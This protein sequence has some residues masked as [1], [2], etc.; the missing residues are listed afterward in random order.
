[1]ED[2]TL[3]ENPALLSP[4]FGT[5][6]VSHQDKTFWANVRTIGQVLGYTRGDQVRLYDLDDL[7][8]AMVKSGLNVAH[9]VNSDGSP[10][11]LALDLLAYF[12]YR[13]EI[14]NTYVRPRL[15]DS[16]RAQQTYLELSAQ[17]SPVLAAPF[18]KQK[19]EKRQIAYLTAIVNMIIEANL[20]G[21]PCDYN[22]KT[23]T[24]I[25][26]DGAPLR[27]LARRVDGCFPS[28]INPIAIWEIKE[29]YYT[30]T[31][32][33]RIAD[34]VYE[35]LLDGLELEELQQSQAI[36]IQHLLVVDAY[37]TW[38][39]MGKSYLCRIID[40]LHMGYIDDV[41]FGYE[42]VEQLPQLVAGWVTTHRT[43]HP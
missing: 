36:K 41:L 11:P 40:M 33:S 39:V 10:S 29:Y 24:T 18:N 38:W 28:A 43:L 7:K 14:L 27:T 9:L 4:F 6:I 1:V 12:F 8:T 35:T 19:G 5:G 15:M 34:G 30:T 23:L 16:Q 25:A 13:A 22:P 37:L 20:R 26:R 32:G 3:L 31:F 17:L 42:V 21:L 2:T